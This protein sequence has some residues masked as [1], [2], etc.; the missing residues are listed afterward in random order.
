MVLSTL[1]LKRVNS[2]GIRF[3]KGEKTNELIEKIVEDKL[4]IAVHELAGMVHWGPKRHVVKVKTKQ[5]YQHICGRY[6]G[7]PIRLDSNHE[8][9]IDDLSSQKNRVKITRIPLEM[10]E[11]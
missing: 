5:M 11:S 7:Y 8:I 9:E 4:G 2:V 10:S 6:V 1:Q 3:T